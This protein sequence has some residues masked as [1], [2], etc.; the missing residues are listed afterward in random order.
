M[1][2]KKYLKIPAA[3]QQANKIKNEA[4]DK[5]WCALK[6]YELMFRILL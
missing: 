2:A 1:S 6:R 4:E 3:E 5:L